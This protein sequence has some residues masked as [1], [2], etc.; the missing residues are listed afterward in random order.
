MTE[1]RITETSSPTGDTHTT[2]TVISDGGSSGSS[3]GMLVVFL[4]LAM[5]GFVVFT[6]MSNSEIAKDNAV[7][8]AANQVGNAAEQVGDAAQTAGE[9]VEGAVDQ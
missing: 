4:I 1:E 5:L 3:W 8:E 2:R 7:T 6:Q 9:A